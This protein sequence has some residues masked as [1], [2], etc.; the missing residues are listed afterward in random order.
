MNERI[1]IFKEINSL[2]PLIL[3]QQGVCCV[4]DSVY[5]WIYLVPSAVKSHSQ[6]VWVWLKS[7][8][9]KEKENIPINV[10]CFSFLPYDRQQFW[11][12]C[13]RGLTK[14][15]WLLPQIP[16]T[17]W[18]HIQVKINHF[19]LERRPLA[20]QNREDFLEKGGKRMKSSIW[21]RRL[22]I[23]GLGCECWRQ[24]WV[25]GRGIYRRETGWLTG[26]TGRPETEAWEE[27]GSKQLQGSRKGELLATFVRDQY[28]RIMSSNSLCHPCLNPVQVQISRTRE[29]VY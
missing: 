12:S 24:T 13:S 9:Q 17:W 28:L 16:S 25:P 15:L 11:T 10:N 20:S 14:C 23:K 3:Q 29:E 5:K 27:E 4:G 18:N 2:G 22:W 7:V 6:Y 1:F 8:W 26:L 21:C 19:K